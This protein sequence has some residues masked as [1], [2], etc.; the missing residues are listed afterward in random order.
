M[1]VWYA[2]EH[3]TSCVAACVRMILTSFGEDWTEAQVR[4]VLG[5]PRLGITLTAAHAR[6]MHA[7]ARAT[8]HDDWSLDDLREALGPKPLPY[9]GRGTSPTWLS[10]CFACDRVGQHYEPTRTRP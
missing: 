6:L 1:L 4:G 7:G 2:Q 10:A 3:P 9:R 5:R 8:L